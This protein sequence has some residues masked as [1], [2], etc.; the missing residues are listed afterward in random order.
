MPGTCRCCYARA[1]EPVLEAVAGEGLYD[2]VVVG[3]AAR[4]VPQ[5]L[6][7]LLR[8]GGRLVVAVGRPL[9]LQVH[10]DWVSTPIGSRERWTS[11]SCSYGKLRAKFRDMHVPRCTLRRQ[12]VP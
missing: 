6:V 7:E 12:N 1:A 8:P 3:A 10:G 5:G 9:Q 4:S 2:A 11:S